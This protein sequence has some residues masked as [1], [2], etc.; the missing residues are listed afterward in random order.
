M[1][2][3][4]F[5]WLLT[6]DIVVKTQAFEFLDGPCNTNMLRNFPEFRYLNWVA[7]TIVEEIKFILGGSLEYLGPKVAEIYK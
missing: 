2:V 7:I 3:T 5:S 6:C 4:S 1:L